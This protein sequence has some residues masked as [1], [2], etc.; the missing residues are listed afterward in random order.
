MLAAELFIST[1]PDSF[2]FPPQHLL[3][4]PRPPHPHPPLRTRQEDRSPLPTGP[5]RPTHLP[6]RSIRPFVRLNCAAFPPLSLYAKATLSRFACIHSSDN[7]RYQPSQPIPEL[8]GSAPLEF[9][10]KDEPVPYTHRVGSLDTHQLSTTPGTSDFTISPRKVQVDWKIGIK[11]CPC[12]QPNCLAKM[13]CVRSGSC[14]L[15]PA[16]VSLSE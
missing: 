4:R 2:R 16:L 8:K 3:H 9:I 10:A 6:R 7:P 5:R 1:F 11:Q 14:L 15:A 13:H 12:G